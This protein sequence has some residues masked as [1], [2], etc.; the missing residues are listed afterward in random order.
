MMAVLRRE[1]SGPEDLVTNGTYSLVDLDGLLLVVTNSHVYAA[2][3]K[4]RKEAPRAALACLGHATRDAVPLDVDDVIADGQGNPDLVT[5]RI[6]QEQAETFERMGKTFF[7]A[8][9]WPPK[10]PQVGNTAALVGFPALHRK[11]SNRGL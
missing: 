5:F 7:R 6:S 11:V 3:A 10:R 2:L 1:Q 4:T 9:G 8:T